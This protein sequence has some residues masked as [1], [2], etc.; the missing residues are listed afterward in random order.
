MKYI[1]Y[2]DERPID[3]QF[4]G[5]IMRLSTGP[6][7]G[8]L[9]V[10]ASLV[11][12]ALEGGDVCLDLQSVAGREIMTG[13]E[14]VSIPELPELLDVLSRSGVVS[15]G[16]GNLPLVK[17]RGSLLY[18]QRYHVAESGL[19]RAILNRCL[20]PQGDPEKEARTALL[21]QLFPAESEDGGG[22]Q[23]AAALQALRR[24]F[25][26]IAGGPGTGKTTTVVKILALLAG[27]DG[28]GGGRIA[29]AAPTGKA[30]LRLSGSVRMQ[31]AALHCTDAARRAIP[32]EASTLHRLLQAVPGTG[33]FRHGPLN[34]LPYDTV[35]VDEASMVALPLM[36][37][38][39][40]ALSPSCRLI[41]LGDPDQ[42]ASVEAGAVLGDICAAARL[43]GSALH[44]SVTVLERNYRFD[45]GSD[46][47][48]LARAVNG[49]RVEESLGLLAPDR[50]NGVVLRPP[51]VGWNERDGVPEELA[52]AIMEGYRPFLEA[53]D[54]PS[55]LLAF[56]RFRMLGAIGDGPGLSGVRGLNMA[57]EQVLRRAGLIDPSSPFYHGRPV[58]VRENDY[59][60]RLF[61]GDTGIVFNDPECDAPLVWFNAPDGSLRAVA[62]ERLP[63]HETAY[64]VTIH[65]SQ[66]SEF[67]AVLMVLPRQDSPLLS[68]ELLY[69]AI[70]RARRSVEIRADPEA[71]SAA[72]RKGTARVSGLKD[73]LLNP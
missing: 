64:A 53:G 41:L 12:R 8:V 15:D 44:G 23:R 5:F 40:S 70:T 26:V 50:G 49:G 24:R 19:A 60:M 7:K 55:A 68:R 25:S 71:L 20:E 46:I 22:M 13:E 14:H 57:A 17:G 31:K 47:S 21:L 37:A 34:P 51:Y 28:T 73:A 4:G 1:R 18:L 72:I 27:E 2:E 11:S 62:P 45:G 56:D 36:H 67:D 32:D 39:F 30:A 52:D 66:G 61:N 9:R 38:F 16:G 29:M 58:M 3:R 65:K 10:L 43:P 59:S 63:K 6:G 69:T 33:R 54:P 35:V 48:D 42:L